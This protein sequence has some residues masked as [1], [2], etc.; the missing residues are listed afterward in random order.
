MDERPTSQSVEERR[1]A[2]IA[3]RKKQLMI[4]RIK[5]FG[6]LGVIL[7]AIILIIVSCTRS[8]K[9]KEEQPQTTTTTAATTEAPTEQRMVF[10]YSASDWNLI[11]VNDDNPLPADFKVPSFQPLKG[12][13]NVDERC[14]NDLQAL[15]DACRAAFPT[16]NS[17]TITR[18]YEAGNEIQD[19][20]DKKVKE[21]VTLG[22]T[23]EQAEKEA[24]AI[25][26]KPGTSEYQTGLAVDIFDYSNMNHDETQRD[27]KV[28]QWLQEHAWEYGF[29]QRF[30]EDKASITGVEE[31]QPWHYRYVGRTPAKDMHD[32]N[33]CLEELI[34]LLAVQ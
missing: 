18:S 33:L 12:N 9:K 3:K 27:N 6:I 31:Y 28:Q 19:A 11:L 26:P 14:Y 25:M 10:S 1:Q 5:F 2:R 29:V 21:L 4:E 32:N 30:P 20:Y 23:Q 16:E 17:A 24:S 34:A 15:M 8:C 7:L 22:Y 13:Q